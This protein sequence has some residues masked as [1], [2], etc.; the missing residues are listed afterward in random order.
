M[1]AYALFGNGSRFR[2]K[3]KLI[4][5]I[6]P[7]V[8]SSSPLSHHNK[9]TPL[10]VGGPR[11][12]TLTRRKDHLCHVIPALITTLSPDLRIFIPLHVLITGSLTLDS[13][14]MHER[15]YL[16]HFPHSQV[17]DLA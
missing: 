6:A 1:T 2:D 17:K 12:S 10:L 7:K 13:K 15:C 11:L 9:S 3:S 8:G 14:S 16:S 5:H 4:V